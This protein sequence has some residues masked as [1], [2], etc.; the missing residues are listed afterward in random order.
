MSLLNYL[1]N[2]GGREAWAKMVSGDE[3]NRTERTSPC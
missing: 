1:N 3:A 2:K